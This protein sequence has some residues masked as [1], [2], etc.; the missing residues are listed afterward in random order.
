MPTYIHAR[1]QALLAVLFESLRPA[2][3]L[4]VCAGL[5][6]KLEPDVFRIPDICVIAGTQPKES[7]PD[8]PPLVAI[9]ILSPDDRHSHLM[10]KLEE[11]LAWGVPN[12]WVIDPATRRFSTYTEIGLQNV[13]SFS[14]AGYPFELT[15]LDLFSR[16]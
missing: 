3:A 6:C 11:Y 12:I 2:H 10:R 9:E 7:V 13:S 4:F 8:Q 16:L 5:R 1:I 14:L 15:P